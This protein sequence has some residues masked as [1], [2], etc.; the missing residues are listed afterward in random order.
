MTK[1]NLFD[2][3]SRF[4]SLNIQDSWDNSGWQIRLKN[5]KK[6]VLVALSLTKE[7]VEE[8][9]EKD[10][11]TI[12][13]HHP[14]FFK[15][16]KRISDSSSNG[17]LIISLIKN[18]ISLYSLHTP[19]DNGFPGIAD[20]W[21]DIF[22]L[23]N[24]SPIV[25]EVEFFKVNIFVP[26]KSFETFKTKI[27][28][29]LSTKTPAETK[30][31]DT[32]FSSLGT[33]EFTPVNDANPIIGKLNEVA[34]VE[35]I[36]MEIVV[37]QEQI[38]QL[39]NAIK[40]FHPYEEPAF[41]I[42]PTKTTGKQSFIGTGRKGSLEKEL[43]LNEI[44][45]ILKSNGLTDIKVGGKIFEKYKK[46]FVLPGSGRSFLSKIDKNALYISSDL[47]YHDAEFASKHNFT[48]IDTHHFEIESVFKQ[49]IFNIAKQHDCEEN[50]V[51]SKKESNYWKNI[52]N[53]I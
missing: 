42:L 44:L 49:I 7:V 48:I 10:V 23:K 32:S 16:I 13:T 37:S 25:S 27:N 24:V 40:L 43:S 8:A 28:T 21:T 17:N 5:N 41:E 45:A 15:S 3:L 53:L 14:L 38:S 36:K 46:I 30:Y 9:I 35:E 1:C 12:L 39:A 6:S 51:L 52:N 34:R 18:N 26:K 47:G 22:N 29:F 2:I 20:F 50:I 31:K 19:V 4:F 11:G 33:G